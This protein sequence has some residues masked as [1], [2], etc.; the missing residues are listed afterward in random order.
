[1]DRRRERIILKSL[2]KRQKSGKK[3]F[4]YSSI[5]ALHTNTNIRIV[6]TTTQTTSI[7]VK[8]TIILQPPTSRQILAGSPKKYDAIYEK[9]NLTSTNLFTIANEIKTRESTASVV[10][11]TFVLKMKQVKII[12]IA[13]GSHQRSLSSSEIP[14]SSI[15][16]NTKEVSS[17]IPS[18]GYSIICV[19]QH[20]KRF[21]KEEDKKAIRLHQ[22]SLASLLSLSSEVPSSFSNSTKIIANTS[23]IICV[24]K[25]EEEEEDNKKDG[26]ENQ[27]IDFFQ[28][29]VDNSRDDKDEIRDDKEG[30]VN[31]SESSSRVK[32]LLKNDVKNADTRYLPTTIADGGGGCGGGGGGLITILLL[33]LSI[34]G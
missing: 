32:T 33:K 1:M 12:P 28:N 25:E 17:N 7:L 21:K 5:P 20:Q 14:S 3:I 24:K 26:D 34:R 8:A 9:L 6:T 15:M 10:P 29:P 18:K 27:G 2:W 23:I 11:K 31:T 4:E 19:Q 13:A 16:I 22:Q 30:K